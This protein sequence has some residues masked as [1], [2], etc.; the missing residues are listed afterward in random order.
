MVFLY[1][2]FLC[3][4]LFSWHLSRVQHIS[5]ISIPSLLIFFHFYMVFLYLFLLIWINHIRICRFYHAFNILKY[6]NPL[7]SI[8]IFLTLFYALSLFPSFR[9][10]S[11]Q[12][13]FFWPPL[14]LGRNQLSVI[15]LQ[16]ILWHFFKNYHHF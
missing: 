1:W 14:L 2:A 11:P 5:F 16:V 13:I 10:F 7:Y 4:M 3:S 12:E 9:I 6:F 8:F 15:S